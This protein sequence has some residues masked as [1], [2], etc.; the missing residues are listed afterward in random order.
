MNPT[1]LEMLSLLDGLG[2]VRAVAAALHLSPSA[3][4]AQLAVLETEAGAEL[5]HRT[6]R[7]VTLTPAGHTLARHARIILDQLRTAKQELQSPTGEPAGHVRMAAFSSAIRAL[8]I[9]LGKRLAETHPAITLTVAEL[10]PMAAHQ[11]LRRGEYDII[12]TADFID[13]STTLDPTLA[14]F[15]LLADDVV[16][17]VPSPAPDLSPVNLADLA[18]AAWSIDMPGTYLSNLVTS[19]CRRAGFEPIITGRFSSYELLLTHVEAGLSI[20]LLPSLAIDHRYHV[21]PR[22]LHTPLT[23]HVYAATRGTPTPPPATRTVLTTLQSLTTPI[24]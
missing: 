21:S 6:G 13:G 4:S 14:T 2:T 10:D 8:A 15:P 3:V 16:L 20:S 24:P 9:P 23:R 18:D 19:T 17:V 11:A 1:R 5:L 7:R 12:V 22:P